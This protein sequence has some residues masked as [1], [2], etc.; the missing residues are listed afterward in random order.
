MHCNAS[1]MVNIG[2][3]EDDR[4][5]AAGKHGAVGVGRRGGP[6]WLGAVLTRI[7]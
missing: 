1:K 4:V 2:R 5:P 6:S 7:L 3:F